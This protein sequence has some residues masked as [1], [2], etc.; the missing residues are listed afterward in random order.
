MGG[1]GTWSATSKMEESFLHYDNKISK[2]NAYVVTHEYGHLLHLSMAKKRGV[3]NRVFTLNAGNE[4][5]KT[6]IAKYGFD[7]SQGAV[8]TYSK[9]NWNEFFAETFAGYHLGSNHPF[10]KAMGDFLAKHHG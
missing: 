7:G 1:R 3:S 4:I 5:I 8:S 9:T 6:A 10:A 2:L